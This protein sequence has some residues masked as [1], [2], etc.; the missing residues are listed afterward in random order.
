MQ[1][2]CATRQARVVMH[3]TIEEE[4][5]QFMTKHRGDTDLEEVNGGGK[6]DS[7][8]AQWLFH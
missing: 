6:I 1:L 7:V 3:D 5:G 8:V 2:E 4:E